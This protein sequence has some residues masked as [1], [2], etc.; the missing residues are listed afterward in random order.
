MNL[1]LIRQD[2]ANHAVYGS[3]V[4]TVGYML[5]PVINKPALLIGALLVVAFAIAKEIY[6][7]VSKKGTPDPL[8]AIATV[9][10]A[11]PAALVAFVAKNGA[12]PW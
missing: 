12:S 2:L 6:D 8:D 7:K 4:F 5:A 1:P 3:V 11:A 10:G 9:A